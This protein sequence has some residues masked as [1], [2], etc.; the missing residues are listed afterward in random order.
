MKLF[1]DIQESVE[2]LIESVNG[3]KT[4][5]IKGV[6]MQAETPNRNGR[7]YPKQIMEREVD[8]YQTLIKEKRALSELGHPSSPTVNLDRV[9]HLITELKM[10][11]NGKDIHGKAKILD[12]PFGKI[13][14]NF[15]DEGIKLGVST[16]GLGSLV[17]KNGI[18]E[19]QNDFML[20][21]IDIVS[22]P[23]GIDCWVDGIMESAEW[24]YDGKNW[25]AA[26]SVKHTIKKMSSK[27]LTE[28][29]A[30]LFEHFLKNL[31]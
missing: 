7:V 18:N 12:T 23:S 5:Y 27:E 16:R 30:R 6:F 24:I 25:I 17:E 1:T 19:V 8:K 2:P 28:Q 10:D 14:K 26:E 20:S 21:A 31:K 13:A 11:K 9:S 29:K 4:H 3:N 22:F 15:L